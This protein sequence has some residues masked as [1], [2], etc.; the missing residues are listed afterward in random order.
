MIKVKVNGQEWQLEQGTTVANLLSQ[1]K[2]QANL[3]VVEINGE[4]VVAGDYAKKI[5]AVGDQVEIVRFMAG[6]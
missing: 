2:I 6:G 4:V 3:S 5:V 1:R